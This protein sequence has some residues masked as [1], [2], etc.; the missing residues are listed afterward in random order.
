MGTA[1]LS[2]RKLII[3]GAFTVAATVPAIAPVFF[4]P[5]DLSAQQSGCAHGEDSDLYTGACVPYLVPNSHGA[6]NSACPPGVSGAECG[7]S[8][9]GNFGPHM[10]APVPPSPEEQELADVVTPGY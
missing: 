5:V 7:G 2:A 9:G 3:A 1:L 6:S 8:T 10:P 4:S